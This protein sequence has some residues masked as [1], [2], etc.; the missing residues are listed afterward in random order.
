[1]F[2]VAKYYTWYVKTANMKSLVQYAHIFFPV[3]MNW[4]E[5]HWQG[6]IKKKNWKKNKKNPAN[7]LHGETSNM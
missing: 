6:L 4:N 5:G 3:M 1:M 2:D 7:Y